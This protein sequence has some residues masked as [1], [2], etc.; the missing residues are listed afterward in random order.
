MGLSFAVLEVKEM[1][2]KH[3]FRAQ[4]QAVNTASIYVE[5][6]KI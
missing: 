4:S 1:S 5:R 3:S 6:N 2:G